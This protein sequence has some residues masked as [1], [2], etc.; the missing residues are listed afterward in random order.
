MAYDKWTDDDDDDG[1]GG[2]NSDVGAGYL[3]FS[4]NQAQPPLHT[5]LALISLHPCHN[6]VSRAHQ[7]PLI[8]C[9]G[10]FVLA[11]FAIDMRTFIPVNIRIIYRVMMML[12]LISD[13]TQTP[14]CSAQH[15][16][17]CSEQCT[18]NS[19]PNSTPM[20]PSPVEEGETRQNPIIYQAII[21]LQP[22]S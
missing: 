22:S 3:L 13:H 4:A 20:Y 16:H 17:H 7:R 21:T 2:N 1:G 10:W 11:I 15:Q 14:P 12:I 19:S 8:Q 18:K 9:N 6:Y 5:H